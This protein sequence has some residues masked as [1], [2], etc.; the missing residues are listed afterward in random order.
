MKHFTAGR[1][2]EDYGLDFDGNP[3]GRQSHIVDCTASSK[4]RFATGGAVIS[5]HNKQHTGLIS[6]AHSRPA[7]LRKHNS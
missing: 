2:W 3:A 1:R 7:Y 5:T 4:A 6:V